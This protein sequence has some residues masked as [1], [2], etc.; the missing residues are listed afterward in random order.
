MKN[1][2]YFDMVEFCSYGKK[3]S[4]HFSVECLDTIQEV[5]ND[6]DTNKL[7]YNFFVGVKYGILDRMEALL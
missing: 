6:S 3:M 2:Q 1:N 5:L 4:K 7:D